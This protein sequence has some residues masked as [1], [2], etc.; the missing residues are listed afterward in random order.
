MNEIDFEIRV[1]E[2]TIE[3]M[4]SGGI[5]ILNIL[6]VFI[7][8]A[9]WASKVVVERQLEFMAQETGKKVSQ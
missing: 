5:G 8:Q 7:K 6:N 3:A 4:K 9:A 1:K 2:L